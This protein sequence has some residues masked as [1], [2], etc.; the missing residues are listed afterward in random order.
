MKK[1]LFLFM[2]IAMPLIAISQERFY[3]L[4]EGWKINDIMIIDGLYYTYGCI[5]HPNA[6]GYLPQFNILHKSG[7]LLEAFTYYSDTVDGLTVYRSNSYLLR[8]NDTVIFV[9][10]YTDYYKAYGLEPIMMKYNLETRTMDTIISY[11]HCV[12]TSNPQKAILYLIDTTETGFIITGDYSY[13][14]QN[15]FPLVIFTNRAGDTLGVKQY[16][17]LP[18]NPYRRR[19]FPYQ[20]IAVPAGGY[21]MSCQDEIGPVDIWPQRQRAWFVRLDSAGNELWRRTTA[22]QDT[23]CYH[24]FAFVMPDGDYLITWS[25]NDLYHANNNNRS[26]W[27]A[28]MDNNG[29]IS[30]KRKIQ[31]YISELPNK[32]FWVNDYYQDSLGN[33][34]LTGE[35]AYYTQPGFILKINPQGEVE[36]YRDYVCFPENNVN[37]PWTKF[38]SITPTPDGGF[39]MGGEYYSPPSSMF[40]SG[41]QKGL[42]VKVD[43]C[44]CLEEDCNPDCYNGYS[45]QTIKAMQAAVYPNPVRDVVTVSLPMKGSSARIELFDATGCQWVDVVRECSETTTGSEVKLNV[46][47]LPSG[48]YLLNVWVGGKLCT[49]K[50]AVE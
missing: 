38:Y 31:D 1:I 26:I 19:V 33:I 18:A 40:P 41:V 15:S 49:G 9:G 32:Y 11:N 29:N 16:P 7:T 8:N 6:A 10:S 12:Q 17:F 2:A 23:I 14:G 34:Y 44:G 39:I 45:T 4:Y 21:L 47:G 30:Q 28:R 25:D 20:T 27:L 13:N 50:V 35:A 37:T 5:I 48:V 46:A 22:T 43:A 36:W 24:P 42:A 3:N